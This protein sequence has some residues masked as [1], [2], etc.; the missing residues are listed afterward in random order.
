MCSETLGIVARAT[1]DKHED[2]RADILNKREAL[3]R[4][5]AMKSALTHIQENP[6]ITMLQL[7]GWLVREGNKAVVDWHTGE[8]K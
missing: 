1:L 2:R 8:P 7:R 4:A 3:G 5:K 6:G